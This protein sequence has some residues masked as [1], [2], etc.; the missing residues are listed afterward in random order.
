[1]E[2]SNNVVDFTLFVAASVI[3]FSN[4]IEVRNRRARPFVWLLIT[5]LLVSIAQVVIVGARLKKLPDLPSCVSATIYTLPIVFQVDHL[6]YS[7][8]PKWHA[9]LPWWV[10]M[11][12]MDALKVKALCTREG[13][14]VVDIA[15]SFARGLLTLALFVLLFL[16]LGERPTTGE[17]RSSARDISLANSIGSSGGMVPWMKRFHIFLPLVLPS[18]SE[19][20]FQAISAFSLKLFLSTLVRWQVGLQNSFLSR[21][22]TAQSFDEFLDIALRFGIVYYA[23]NSG[24]NFIATLVWEKFAS[25]RDARAEKYIHSFFMTRDASFHISMEP[26]IVGIITSG[27]LAILQAL[28]K[29]F[30]ETVPK[31]WLLLLAI[32]AMRSTCG[33][34]ITLMAC[35]VHVVM[36]IVAVRQNKKNIPLQW[37]SIQAA[38]KVGRIQHDGIA[39]FD[40]VHQCGQT[41]RHIRTHSE[42]VDRKADLAFKKTAVYSLNALLMDSSKTLLIFGCIW[43]VVLRSFQVKV[44]ADSVADFMGYELRI[45]GALSFFRESSDG[46]FD[47]LAR[48]DRLLQA[49]GTGSRMTPGEENLHDPDGDIELSDVSY[50]YPDEKALIFNK[51]NVTIRPGEIT[52]IVGA[53]GIGKT[54]FLY[55]LN[56]HLQV[57]GGCIKIGGQALQDVKREQLEEWISFVDQRV[58]I[59]HE[60][61]RYN[62]AYGRPEASLDE[63]ESAA[64][65]VGIHGEIMAMKHQYDEMG[66]YG[67]VKLSGGQRQRIALARARLRETKVL[68]ADEP[69]SALDQDAR[70]HAMR[71]LISGHNRTIVFVSHDLQNVQ[72][73]D[74]ILVFKKGAMGTE[75]AED[76]SHTD[77]LSQGGEYARLWNQHVG[78]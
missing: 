78:A 66:G 46:L 26:H 54:T 61:M 8:T 14:T 13:Q 49:F 17:A 52:M 55:L 28:D 63:I 65:A 44:P 50:A 39:A 56:G 27:G 29:L 37:G 48:A 53:S 40:T 1:M 19:E 75:I 76:G 60:T 32:K 42:A 72:Y 73:A 34:T 67:G 5:I 4:T 30:L 12:V 51:L 25:A 41:G 23:S 31:A 6:A 68:L 59:F 11:L 35:Y 70:S 69:T 57:Q 20:W 71:A 62:I 15:T 16:D 10:M 21:A 2:H 58:Y 3:S 22:K 18:S 33:S 64:K 7:W 24:I 36:L 43:L 74:R 38:A 77:L 47:S 45:G 9:C